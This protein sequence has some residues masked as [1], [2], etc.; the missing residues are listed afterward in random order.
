MSSACVDCGVDLHPPIC[1]VCWTKRLTTFVEVVREHVDATPCRCE[2]AFVDRGL[3]ATDCLWVDIA[4]VR[5]AMGELESGLHK[6]PG[7]GT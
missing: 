1:G 7:E 2:P 3:H 6:G 5:D 4:A